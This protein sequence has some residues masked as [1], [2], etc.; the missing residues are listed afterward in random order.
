MKIN[1]NAK[2]HVSCCINIMCTYLSVF[3]IYMFQ[4]GCD[5]L[6]Y[7]YINTTNYRI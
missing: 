4:K 2:Q 6:W 7:W 5:I 3:Y 1:T